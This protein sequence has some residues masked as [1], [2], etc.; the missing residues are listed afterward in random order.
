MPVAPVT[1]IVPSRI[2]HDCALTALSMLVGKSYHRV[3][4]AA[5]RR[6]PTYIIHHGLDGDNIIK[7]A[8]D[9]RTRLRYLEPFDPTND[10]HTEHGLLLLRRPDHVVFLRRGLVVEAEETGSLWDV[11]DYLSHHHP[12]AV[13][14]LVPA[15]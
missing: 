15:A 7:L 11:E 9:L 1:P 6:W 8:R 10:E 5:Y 3:L 13:G 14:V 12:H 4:R 2:Q